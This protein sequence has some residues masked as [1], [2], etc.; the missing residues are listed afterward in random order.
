MDKG[1]YSEDVDISE[2]G[3]FSFSLLI[4]PNSSSNE[5]TNRVNLVPVCSEV[6]S[7]YSSRDE[8]V[9]LLSVVGAENN[10][11]QWSVGVEL[12]LGR[13]HND[14]RHWQFRG[15]QQ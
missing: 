9:S 6:V 12:K 1:R 11:N 7:M 5:C 10:S 14:F 3:V 4:C 8:P 15:F 2:W 13:M